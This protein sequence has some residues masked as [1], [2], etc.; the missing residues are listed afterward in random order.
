MTCNMAHDGRGGRTVRKPGISGI[1][2]KDVDIN[3][4]MLLYSVEMI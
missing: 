3:L 1:L 2:Y 4:M